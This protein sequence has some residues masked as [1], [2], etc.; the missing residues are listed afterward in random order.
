MAARRRVD[1][2]QGHC[3]A[4]LGH[5]DCLPG[6]GQEVAAAQ[7]YGAKIRGPCRP[8]VSAR[9]RRPART[10]TS[11]TD[12]RTG[13]ETGPVGTV[14][15]VR[16]RTAAWALRRAGDGGLGWRRPGFRPETVRAMRPARVK[17]LSFYFVPWPPSWGALPVPH[18]ATQFLAP[19]PRRLPR[20][21]VFF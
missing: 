16:A 8:W 1:I 4:A 20:A 6:A 13:P 19:P 18:T 14:V 9:D 12:G 3:Q 17:P 15:A 2:G 10:E 5:R 21:E 7:P 11:E